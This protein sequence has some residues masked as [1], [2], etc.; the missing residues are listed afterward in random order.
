MTSRELIKMWGVVLASVLVHL[1]LFSAFSFRYEPNIKFIR[2]KTKITL[3]PFRPLV[4][5]KV[6]L[7]KEEPVIPRSGSMVEESKGGIKAKEQELGISRPSSSEEDLM[8]APEAAGGEVEDTSVLSDFLAMIRSDEFQK[9]LEEIRREKESAWTGKGVG[10]SDLSV[11]EGAKGGKGKFEEPYLDPRVRLVV[12]SYPKTS[13]EKEHPYIT[14]PDLKVKKYELPSGWC[15]VVIRI[16][17]DQRGNVVSREILRPREGGMRERLF[18]EH[19]L[20][21]L[22]S[23]KFPRA[24]SEIIIDVRYYVE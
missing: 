21:S 22:K 2:K 13:I 18:L 14:Y 10:K 19:T 3:H 23:W 4:P 17:T 5:R 16:Y 24:K 6:S 11:P 20:E 12:V 9:R 7:K 1:L 8:P 15:N